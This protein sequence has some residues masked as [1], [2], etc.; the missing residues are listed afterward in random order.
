[1]SNCNHSTNPAIVLTVVQPRCYTGKGPVRP[2]VTSQN[3][4][5]PY[6]S[7]VVSRIKAY[8]EPFLIHE[9]TVS[10]LCRNCP[11]GHVCD[12]LLDAS[13]Y[14][15]HQAY[16][17]LP[18]E[19][20][21]DTLGRELQSLEVAELLLKARI[22]A[23]KKDAVY[24]LE[25]GE[26]VRGYGLVTD[27]S[28]LQWSYEQDTLISMAELLGLDVVK[29]GVKTPTQVKNTKGVDPALVDSLAARVPTKPQL[30]QDGEKLSRIFK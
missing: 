4:L 18:V 10:P 1:L 27:M 16:D 14:A 23:L 24:R 30:K 2:W 22:D 12:A 25:N 17:N 3:E 11:A 7:N 21:G 8:Y 13:A 29:V 19:L 9:C 15:I 28:P 6:F 5:I 20:S 26:R